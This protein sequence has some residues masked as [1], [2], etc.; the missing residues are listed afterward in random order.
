MSERTQRPAGLREEPARGRGWWSVLLTLV[1]AVVLLG[2]AYVGAAYYFKDRPPAGVSVAGV[3][4]GSLTEQQA[5][6]VLSQQLAPLTSSA[7]T[8]RAPVPGAAEDE[9]LSLVPDEAG[10]QLD[11]DA[12]LAGVTTLSFH[13][14]DLWAHVAGTDRELAL[15]TTVDRAQLDAAVTALAQ[16]F[17]QEPEDGE[18]VIGPDG[19]ESR[20]AV[21]G[22]Q[23]DVDATAEHVQEAWL[24]QEFVIG[25]G[26]EVAGRSAEVAPALTQAEIDRFTQQELQPALAEPVLVTATRG[27][28]EDEVSATAELAE[29]DLR[30]LLSVEEDAGVLTL[31]LDEEALHS[32]VRQDLGQL[33]A[34]PRDAT[35]RL[36]GAEVEVVPSQVGY[37]LEEEGLADA[38]LAALPEQGEGRR[39]EADVSVV[40][41]AIATE[42]SEG[43]RFSPMGSFVSAF[44]TGPANEARTAN[45]RAGVGHVNG[46]VVMPGE[47]FSLGAALGDISEAGGYVEAPV[48]IDGRL[49]MGLGG[50]LSQVSTV[51][52]NTSWN[53]GVQLDA[54]T[55]HSFYIA[56]Y[57]AGREATLAY[58]FIDNLWTND[59]DTPVV[60][61]AWISGDEIHMTY[62]G[63]RQ[64]DVRT[65]DG[66]RRDIT[67]GEE[68]EDDSPDCVPQGRAE[69]FT[70]T[71]TRVLSQGGAEVHRDQY[72]TTY[73]AS[74]EVTCTHPDARNP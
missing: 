72:T 58:P 37:A 44:P 54:H 68:T 14:G 5:K 71:V 38:V 29:R 51:V 33:E 46:T 22:R 67:Q 56:R 64:Y 12:T 2:G 35:V 49:V 10:L 74:D 52:F 30:R 20:D 1:V 18:V 31:H 36:A 3:D 13:P 41:P 19:V 59:T 25:Q 8:V 17:D 70:I 42:V 15:R 73:Q 65:I 34:G 61:Q 43:W 57:P 11:L 50:G 7:I 16:D 28:G 40:E 62:L 45:L 66:D 23:L 4:I 60:V 48:I 21:V 9:E 27:E 39:V 53:A 6:D 47:Q 55:P 24:T 63:Q 69:G 32:R 26:R